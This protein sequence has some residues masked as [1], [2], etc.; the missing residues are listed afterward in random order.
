MLRTQVQDM[1]TMTDGTLKKYLQKECKHKEE[2]L[3][4]ISAMRN[5]A[6]EDG[7]KHKYD[8]LSWLYNIVKGTEV[9]C[10]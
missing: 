1:L 7:N 10:P 6:K 9:L 4:K 8:E 3:S 2:I 5:E